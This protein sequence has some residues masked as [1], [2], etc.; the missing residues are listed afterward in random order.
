MGNIVV[1]CEPDRPVG[2]F[3]GYLG[4]PDATAGSFRGPFYF[5]GDKA[6]RDEDG[7]L[8]F[9]GRNDDVITSARNYSRS[10][11]CKNSVRRATAR[12][13]A[14]SRAAAPG[15]LCKQGSPAAVTAR[16]CNHDE[17]GV[18][19]EDPSDPLLAKRSSTCG[20]RPCPSA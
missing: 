13:S 4:D 18:S 19:A 15:E 3:P 12:S 9:E 20:S 2:L 11:R 17:A 5:T 7:Y 1:R 10:P 16:Y 6:A 14:R 8:W